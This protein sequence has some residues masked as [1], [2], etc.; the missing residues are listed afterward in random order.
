MVNYPQSISLCG[1]GGQGIVLSAVILGT[2]A[3]T[4]GGL[5]AV[6]TQSYGSE[7][8]GGQ[9]QAE[10]I[11][12]T[13]PINSPVARTKDLLVA[14]FQDAYNKYI[15]TLD[16]GGVLIIDPGLVTD[17]T[18]PVEKTFALPATQIAV[19][20]GNRMVA[21]MVT[22]GFLS[23]CRGLVNGEDLIQVVLDNV[24]ERFKD[25]N[26]RAVAAGIAYAR[27]NNLYAR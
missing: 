25:L 27:D 7:A 2:A 16:D 13:K 17:L 21:N 15:A 10:L 3:V 1:F 8:R 14:L 6:Q 4:K 26:R 22:L 9:C 12:D 23:E 18:R 19:D 5:Y 24:P 20:L 11:I